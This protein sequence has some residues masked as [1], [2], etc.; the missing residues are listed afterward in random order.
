MEE[1]FF[2]RGRGL[3]RQKR[4]EEKCSKDFPEK[5]RETVFRREGGRVAKEEGR[6]MEEVEIST[7]ANFLKCVGA[8]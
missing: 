4:S 7:E 5:F 8:V 2:S 6:I 1:V 3:I